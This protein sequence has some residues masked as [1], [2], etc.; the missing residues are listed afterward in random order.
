MQ[1]E[2]KFP[3]LLAEMAK[4]G[5]KKSDI[6]VLL[7]IPKPSITKRFAGEIDWRIGEIETICNHYDK[8]YYELFK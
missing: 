4:R 1:K 5:E 2:I 3:G 7:G 8:N 6:A